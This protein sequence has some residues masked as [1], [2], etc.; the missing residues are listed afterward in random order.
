MLALGV[1]ALALAA[2]GCGGGTSAS[3]TT[4]S[5]ATALWASGICTAV[6]TWQT[7]M[8]QIAATVKSGGLSKSA[9]GDAAASAKTATQTLTSTLKGL[10]APKTTSGALAK[11]SVDQLASQLESGTK[12]IEEAVAGGIL[13]AVPTVASTLKLMGSDV[14]STVTDLQNLDV[15]GELDQAFKGA[16][17]CGPLLGE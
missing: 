7:D 1:V 2:A 4:G 14:S 16:D 17:S 11:E 3:T 8:K 10:G 13:T 6:T 5:A 12:T 9:L 15:K